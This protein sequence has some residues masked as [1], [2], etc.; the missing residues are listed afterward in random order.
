LASGV[1]VAEKNFESRSQEIVSS[2]AIETILAGTKPPWRP[3]VAGYVALL[4]GPIAGALV[5]AASFRSMGQ[6]RKAHQTVFYTL[7]LCIAFLI[8]FVLGIPADAPIKK[9]ILLAVEGAGY[10]V[11]P[12]IIRE[13]YV[14]WKAAN[15][16]AKPRNDYASIE[17]GVLGALLYIA[18]GI[19][20]G[21]FRR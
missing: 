9:I 11:F 13:D 6:P 21:A 20:I 16:G 15:P 14:K 5:A 3:K 2:N 1:P 19:L 18:I 10:S 8:P 7:L 12:S 4:L 17:W